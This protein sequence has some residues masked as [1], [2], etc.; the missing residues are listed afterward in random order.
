MFAF[1]LTL[2]LFSILGISVNAFAKINF[3]TQSD[4][5]DSL[6]EEIE[7]A[8][9]KNFTS[10]SQ[11]EV[12]EYIEDVKKLKKTLNNIEIEKSKNSEDETEL[13][14]LVD[15]YN[16]RIAELKKSYKF[17]MSKSSR[18]NCQNEFSNSRSNPISEEDSLNCEKRQRKIKDDR[19]FEPLELVEISG[20]IPTRMN[21]KNPA[22]ILNKSEE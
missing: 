13:Q 18:K 6:L 19:S 14:K 9:I 15:E 8:N 16:R 10:I 12:E 22:E 17:I 3:Q 4:F 7:N 21:S 20:G 1:R 5:L 2:L 11:A